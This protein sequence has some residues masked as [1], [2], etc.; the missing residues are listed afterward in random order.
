MEGVPKFVCEHTPYRRIHTLS[1]FSRKMRTSL[2]F[3]LAAVSCDAFSPAVVVVKRQISGGSRFTSPLT[4]LRNAEGHFSK[5]YTA[6]SGVTVDQIP[7]MIEHLTIEN[8]EESLDLLEPLL[9]NE[10][11]GDVCEDFLDEIEHKMEDMGE[12][13]PQDYASKIRAARP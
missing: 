10:C 7:G 5:E 11:V 1:H 4:R 12:H 9:T 6:S 8:M 3:L 2:F 13:L